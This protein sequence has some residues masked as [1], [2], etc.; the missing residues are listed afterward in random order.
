VRAMPS[1]QA[2]KRKKTFYCPDEILEF[3]AQQAERLGTSENWC[4]IYAVR[5]ARAA[6]EAIPSADALL[7]EVK[8]W[9]QPQAP[10]PG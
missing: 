5:R 7:A 10:N 2:K 8:D 1:Q 4:V 3:I 6:I 9:R